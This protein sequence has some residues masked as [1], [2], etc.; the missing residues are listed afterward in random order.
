MAVTIFV[1]QA[2]NGPPPG[3]LEDADIEDEDDNYDWY[4]LPRA[5]ARVSS[6]ERDVL[7]T[8]SCAMA[9]AARVGLV[10][11]QYGGVFGQELDP[12]IRC[13][14][15]DMYDHTMPLIA[16]VDALALT[17]VAATSSL[18]VMAA[19][20]PLPTEE[21]ADIAVFRAHLMAQTEPGVLPPLPVTVLSGFLGAGKTTLLQHILTNRQGL[22][23]AV[24]VNDMADVNIDA[25][26]VKRGA[27]EVAH[28][29]EELV[30]LTNGCICCTLREDLLRTLLTVAATRNCDYI[31]VEGSG[32]YPNYNLF[33]FFFF[34]LTIISTV[35][36]YMT[37]PCIP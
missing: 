22:K 11:A 16:G 20:P 7:L 28:E 13:T 18:S 23:I 32:K 37:Q 30:E 17:T 19:V 29:K 24:I 26:L 27:G 35:L 2:V 31:V 10:R 34:F 14:G 15:E 33:F 4:T 9:G 36:V 25:E 1:A 12:V 5:L 6:A 3:P 21:N 8:V